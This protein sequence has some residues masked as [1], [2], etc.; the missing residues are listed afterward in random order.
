MSSVPHL[1]KMGFVLEATPAIL[2]QGLAHPLVVEEDLWASLLARL[3]FA[4][5]GARCR[6]VLWSWEGIPGH[7]AALLRTGESVRQRALAWVAR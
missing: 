2:P 5:C 7:F 3:A 4:I 6:S 1:A